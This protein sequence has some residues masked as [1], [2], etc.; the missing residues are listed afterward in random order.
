MSAPQPQPRPT[1]LK[2]TDSPRAPTPTPARSDPITAWLDTLSM[3]L[4]LPSDQRE[5]VREELAGHLKDRGRDL[6]LAGVPETQASHTA[7]EELGDAVKLAHR[8]QAASRSPARRLA[9]N[10]TVVGVASAALIT[11]VIA[12]R[13]GGTGELGQP[14][15]AQVPTS[16]MPAQTAA[17]PDDV[18]KIRL[19]QDDTATWGGFFKQVMDKSKLPVDIRWRLFEAMGFNAGDVMHTSF[20]DTALPQVVKFI[21][22]ELAPPGGAL[23]YRA[24]DGRLVFATQD[25]FDQQE[26][27]L[28]AYDLSKQVA[29][30]AKD[31]AVAPGGLVSGPLPS[32]ADAVTTEVRAVLQHMVHPEGWQDNGGN[33][34]TTAVFGSKLFIK[35]PKR[36]HAEIQWLIDELPKSAEHAEAAPEPL[37][38]LRMLAS[39]RPTVDAEVS[40]P[41]LRD[42]P[43]LMSLHGTR[44]PVEPTVGQLPITVRGEN[45]AQV[46]V[47]GPQGTMKADTV[48]I[49]PPQPPTPTPAPATDPASTSPAPQPPPR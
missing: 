7:L 15:R 12:L 37:A 29:D 18:Q 44:T 31:A 33:M 5:N 43:L 8:L 11:S 46:E 3:V 26:T 47:V 14:G 23:D 17:L 36:Y 19:T 41:I 2:L 40:A 16:T 48:R 27:I 25:Y 24:L 30:R 45:G 21:N 20:H 22:E 35:A 28:V 32:A 9:M 49:N 39:R 38:M 4:K 13:G 6:M 34:A 1:N 42:V 10:I